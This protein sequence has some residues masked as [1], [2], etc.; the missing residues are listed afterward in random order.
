MK[1]SRERAEMVRDLI[2]LIITGLLMAILMS[3]CVNWNKA[4]TTPYGEVIEVA[5]DKVTVR[6]YLLNYEKS[7]IRN[8][9]LHQG[10]HKYEIGDTYPDFR[11]QLYQPFR[12]EPEVKKDSIAGRKWCGSKAGKN[13]N[14]ANRKRLRKNFRQRGGLFA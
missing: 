10:G 5:G 9:Y 14:K 2:R 8:T 7:F 12:F 11:K 6:Y 13:G 3:S 1:I 4:Y